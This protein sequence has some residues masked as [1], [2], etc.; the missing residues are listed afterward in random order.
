MSCVDSP[1]LYVD[2][3]ALYHLCDGHA[4]HGGII[5]AHLCWILTHARAK[6]HHGHFTF[7]TTY[8]LSERM[9]DDLYWQAK[10]NICRTGSTNLS[11]KV[12]LTLFPG[13]TP[14]QGPMGTTVG[15]QAH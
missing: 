2:S 9:R 10:N 13:K 14:T 12:V 8:E 7:N 1:A 3:P 5:Y 15:Q 4:S 11:Q 6:E